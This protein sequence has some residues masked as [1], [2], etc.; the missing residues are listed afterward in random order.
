MRHATPTSTILSSSCSVP[1]V[2]DDA[3]AHPSYQSAPSFL[4]KEVE[5]GVKCLRSSVLGWHRC[6]DGHSRIHPLEPSTPPGRFP[7]FCLDPNSIT[8]KR[9][10][11]PRPRVVISTHPLRPLHGTDGP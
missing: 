3:L 2:H 4:E 8:P 5:G 7:S 9:Q 6:R 10:S 11:G 1:F